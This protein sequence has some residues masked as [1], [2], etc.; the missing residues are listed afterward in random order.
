MIE[1]VNSYVVR[2]HMGRTLWWFANHDTGDGES[3]SLGMLNIQ[4]DDVRGTMV[5]IQEDTGRDY[6]QKVYGKNALV[7]GDGDD[8]ENPR[9]C[10][11]KVMTCEL[12]R[13]DLRG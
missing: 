8:G 4:G 2:Q 3:L 10:R 1:L 12:R 5:W 13:M 7:V 11:F 6:S 9:R